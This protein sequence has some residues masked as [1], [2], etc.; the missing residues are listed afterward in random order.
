MRLAR[1]ASRHPIRSLQRGQREAVHRW[2]IGLGLI[3][4]AAPALAFAAW[5]I[6]TL[7]RT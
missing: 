3:A 6:A 1:T 2:G 5:V 4:V 7:S